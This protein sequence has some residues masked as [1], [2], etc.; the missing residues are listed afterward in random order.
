MAGILVPFSMFLVLPQPPSEEA[1]FLHRFSDGDFGLTGEGAQD[2]DS[3]HAEKVDAEPPG[4]R[5][6]RVAVVKT[7]TCL[8]VALDVRLHLFVFAL[9]PLSWGLSVVRVREC[10]FECA[11]ILLRAQTCVCVY[12]L[13]ISRILCL[14]TCLLLRELWPTLV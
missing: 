7:L 12:V 14:H 1:F 2:S 11:R 4:A 9:V 6:F 3:E 5:D 8:V 13:E 10:L